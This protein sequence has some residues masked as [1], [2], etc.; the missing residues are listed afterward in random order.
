[1]PLREG[2]ETLPYNFC[3]ALVFGAEDVNRTRDL[4]ITKLLLYLLSYSSTIYFQIIYLHRLIFKHFESIFSFFSTL[5]DC[6]S[7]FLESDFL[8]QYNVHILEIFRKGCV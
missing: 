6:G 2:T 4:Q 1:M 8:S 3:S 7:P 5:C